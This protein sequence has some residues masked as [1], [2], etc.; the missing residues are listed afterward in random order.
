[1]SHWLLY[2]KDHWIE[3]DYDPL[4]GG[5]HTRQDP[6]LRQVQRGDSLWVVVNGGAEH[7]DDWF[8]F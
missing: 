2:W 4:D 3:D 1:M 8:L 6:F 5:W 7:Q